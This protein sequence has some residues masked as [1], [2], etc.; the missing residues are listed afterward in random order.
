MEPQATRRPRLGKSSK[1]SGTRGARRLIPAVER[2]RLPQKAGAGKRDSFLPP[3]ILLMGPTAS[4]KTG[5]AVRL[6]E[7]FPI[8]LISVDSA[9][10]YRGMDIGTAK[11]D[12]ATLAAAPHALIDIRDPTQS[13]SAAE[14]RRD[15]LELMAV[16]TARG[17]VPLLVGGTMLYFRAL[18]QGLAEL[19][20]ADPEFRRRL[21]DDATQQGWP[22]LHQRLKA[23]DASSAARIHPNDSQRIQRALEVYELSGKT[24]SALQSAAAE[25]DFPWRSLKLVV[26]PDSRA[27][28]HE[29]IALRF[30]LMH[31]AG[32]I[33]EIQ[34]LRDRY[35][36]KAN[37]PSM[38]CV[39]YRQA[40]AMLEAGVDT[41]AGMAEMTEKTN[42]AT[43]QLAKRQLTWLRQVKD[44]LWYDLGADGA[45]A[46]IRRRVA[47]FL[48]KG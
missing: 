24:L 25:P 27:M 37:M 28:L 9:L 16:Y 38:R 19:P 8:E 35:P 44:A 33:E 46:L 1:A 10:V 45:E 18:T 21:E 6:R 40:W 47:I 12:A 17:R 14:F 41:A 31:K 23:I 30:E 4:G 11:P 32:F 29:R 7:E 39:G 3:C 13:Y 34:G 22:A 26:C 2:S 48:E 15:A 20:S 43:R 5:L 36:L 42:A